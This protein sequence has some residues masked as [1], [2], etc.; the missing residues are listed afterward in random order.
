[1]GL[2]YLR[3]A[4]NAQ[5]ARELQLFSQRLELTLLRDQ[6]AMCSV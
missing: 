5:Y 1:M 3:Q 2:G 6:Q 4:L